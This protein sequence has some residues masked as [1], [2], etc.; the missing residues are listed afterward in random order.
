MIAM[1]EKDLVHLDPPADIQQ[2][3]E[4]GYGWGPT[5]R[6]ATRRS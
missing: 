6:P 5:R 1:T 3:D 2:Y 4:T